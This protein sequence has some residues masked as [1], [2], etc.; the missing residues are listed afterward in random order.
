L[1]TTL[2]LTLNPPPSRLLELAAQVIFQEF[3]PLLLEEII[4]A[5]QPLQVLLTVGDLVKMESLE[6]MIIRQPSLLLSRL[7]GSVVQ[8][9]SQA[10]PQ[11]PLEDFLLV[12]QLKPPFLIVGGGVLNGEHGNN[13]NTQTQLAPINPLILIGN[14]LSISGTLSGSSIFNYTGSY[15]LPGHRVSFISLPEATLNNVT[16]NN[17][18]GRYIVNGNIAL[19]NLSILSGSLRAYYSDTITVSGDWNNQSEF[20]PY[21]GT[22]TLSGAN[23]SILGST[24]FYNLT[25]TTSTADTLT[26]ESGET[27]TIAANGSLTLNG[28]IENLLTLAPSSPTTHSLL[29]VDTTATQSISYVSA[30]YSDASSGETINATSTTNTD[31]GENINWSFPPPPAIDQSSYRFFENKDAV[32][33]DTA[34]ANQDTSI[35]LTTPESTFR[36]RMLLGVS[37]VGLD[38]DTQNFTLQYAPLGVEASCASVN[39]ST[40]NAIG[41]DIVFN[42]NTTPTDKDTITSFGLTSTNT[43]KPQT[44]NESN[45]FSNAVS[46]I[47]IGEDGLWDFSLKLAS[48]ATDGETYCFRAVKQSGATLN[49]YTTYPAVT[50]ETGT[51]IDI[52]GTAYAENGTTPLTSKTVRVKVNGAGDYSTTTDGSGNYSIANVSATTGNV[53]HIYLDNETEKATTVT[54]ASTGN[55]TDLNLTQNIV[56]LRH[57]DV[58][59]ITNTDISAFTSTDDADVHIDFADYTLTIT[60][61]SNLIIKQGK[62]YVPDTQT[63]ITGNLTLETTSTLESSR[64]ITVKGGSVTGEGTFNLTNGVFTLEG[65]GSFGSDTNW[66]FHSLVF[67]DGITSATTSKTGEGDITTINKTEVRSLHTLNASSSLW[68]LEGIGSAFEEHFVEVSAGTSHTCGVTD[69]GHV[70]CWGEGTNGRL[71]PGY[72]PFIQSTPVQVVGVGGTGVLSGVTSVSAGTFHTCARTEEGYAYCW[73]HGANGRLGNNSTSGSQ[74]PSRLSE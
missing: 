63:T 44:Y 16:L 37:E 5:F 65:T 57:E 8:V 19:N 38:I 17:T 10:S 9:H 35:T 26:F 20:I 42:T 6:I 18:N 72:S 56:T 11:S 36:L 32:D 55:I 62:T 53:I 61:G 1:E 71:G 24:T 15:V 73:G 52:S 64:H 31:G 48:T 69:T 21:K 3:L 13:T 60:E 40:Y 29:N 45:P 46:A 4:V 23:Q 67:G 2:L 50:F 49:T 34:L 58:G 74:T 54:R 59:P 70:Y 25:K 33:P 41:T 7:L 30:S 43:I 47:S 68:N 14:P 51:G 39:T 28:A 12:L 27:T 22:V 66:T